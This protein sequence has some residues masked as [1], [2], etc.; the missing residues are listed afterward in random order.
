MVRELGRVLKATDPA[1]AI[2]EIREIAVEHNAVEKLSF[3]GRSKTFRHLRELYGMDP[4]LAIFR[5][6]RAAWH[7]YEAERPLLAALCAMAR[8]PLFRATASV[9]TSSG[10]GDVLSKGVF[11][12][13][14]SACFPGRYS[15]GV[16]ARIGRNIASSWT[17][18]G[19]FSGRLSKRRTRARVGPASLAYAMYL[20]HLTGL[21]GKR[22]LDTVWTSIL[23]CSSVELESLAERASR[24]GWLDYR[25]SGGM[26]DV[27]FRYFEVV[28]EA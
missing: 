18:S 13:E 24:Q 2:D 26:V 22:L 1:D 8:D 20:G 3:S 19:H 5:G 17:Q 25:A 21:S 11:T 6:L 27:T 16:Q 23:D 12:A 10:I 14:I 7:S 9:T 4:G 28:T 15:P